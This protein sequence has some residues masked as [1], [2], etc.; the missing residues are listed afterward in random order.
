LCNAIRQ[1]N[2]TITKM[3]LASVSLLSADDKI[4]LIAK[5]QAIIDGLEFGITSATIR[6]EK[7]L[8]TATNIDTG[9]T[10]Q[11]ALFDAYQTAQSSQPNGSALW[12]DFAE[13]ATIAGEN[14]AKLNRQKAKFGT[15]LVVESESTIEVL[16][17]RITVL[18]GHIVELA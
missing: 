4:K 13:K 3:A 18:Q 5:F 10:T 15:A 17:A 6:K 2:K 11:Q 1:K 12:L 16:Q 14:L 9:I 7:A 8:A